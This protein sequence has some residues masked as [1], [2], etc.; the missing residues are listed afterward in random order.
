M[1]E[2]NTVSETALLT[3]KARAVETV[4]EEP[5]ITDP[6]SIR[7]MESLQSFELSGDQHR[8]L[9]RKPPPSL[10]NYIALRARKYDA[11]AIAFLRDHPDGLVINLGAGL[12][13]RFWRISAGAE[14][15]LELDLPEVVSLK[16]DLLGNRL[17]YELIPGSVLEM[18]WVERLA[19]KQKEHVLFLAEGLLMYL[20][21]TKVVQLFQMLASV[22][23]NSRM[24]FEVVH[25]KYTRGF[26]KKMVESKMKRRGGT[27]AGS[28]Y[29]YG[30]AA[31]KDIQAYAD[32]LKVL[33]EWS[34]LEDPDVRPRS[35]RFLRHFTSFARTQWTVRAEIK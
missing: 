31:G 27:E 10:S 20:P 11:Y 29:N 18:E 24:V 34:Y 25:R 14:Q 26:R 19:A 1:T 23:T 13:T 22:F 6:M 3:L 28:S 15:Y 30:I 17:E 7:L 12:D 9:D 35:L 32:N 21:E 33:E 8:I 5:L 16:K 4:K 2:L